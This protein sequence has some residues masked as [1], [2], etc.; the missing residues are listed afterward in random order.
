MEC[1]F[2]F[3]DFLYLTLLFPPPQIHGVLN[4]VS[5]GLLFPTGVVIARY[6]RVFPSA[7]PAWF[8]LHI[9]CQISAYAIGV[10]GWGTGMKLGSESEGFVAYG[11]RNIGIALFSMATLQVFLQPNYYFLC[12]RNYWFCFDIF[13]EFCKFSGKIVLS[14]SNTEKLL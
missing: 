14:V 5:W 12:L 1:F 6:L 7:D 3:F 11:H 13:S 4:A 9:S 10:A 8:Y 2:F